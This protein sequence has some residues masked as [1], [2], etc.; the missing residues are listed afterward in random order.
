MVIG[1]T[2]C[3]KSSTTNALVSGT[4]TIYKDETNRI[5][6]LN[7]IVVNGEVQ[8]KVGQGSVSKTETPNFC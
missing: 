4:S 5:Y 7:P 1:V 3:G 8:F 6:P 2:G